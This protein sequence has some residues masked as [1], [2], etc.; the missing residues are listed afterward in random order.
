MFF[1]KGTANYNHIGR[2]SDRN[3]HQAPNG[4]MKASDLKREARTQ[5]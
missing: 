4:T 5:M 1:G 2:S 3:D